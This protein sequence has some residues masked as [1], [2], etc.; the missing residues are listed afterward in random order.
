MNFKTKKILLDEEP[1]VVRYKKHAPRYGRQVKRD[2][3]RLGEWMKDVSLRVL[4]AALV[5]W[6]ITLL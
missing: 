4:C 1:E 3:K 6:Q 5:R 2:A